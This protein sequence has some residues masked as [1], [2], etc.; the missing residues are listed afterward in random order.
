MRVTAHSEGQVLGYVQVRV[1]SRVYTL[2]VEAVPL[3]KGDDLGR[4]A[5]FFTDGTD[6][7][8]ILVDRDASDEVQRE[9]IEQGS[10]DAARHLARK[11]LN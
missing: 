7:F 10:V 3:G 2:L 4:K 5:G 1:A 8:G 6:Q 11:F 9:T